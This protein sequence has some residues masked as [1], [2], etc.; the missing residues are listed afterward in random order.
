M[1]LKIF[2]L[3]VLL[4]ITAFMLHSFGW[5]GAPVFA[6]VAMVI[7]LSEAAGVLESVLLSARNMGVDVGLAEP[8]SAALKVLGLGYL[9]GICADVCRDMSESG[10]AKAV[11]AVGRVE[12]VAVVMPF[13][14]EIIKVGVELLG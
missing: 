6:S 3:A 10:I 12:I 9:Y 7:L 5:R 8:V 1:I 2:G 11:E 13:F 4:C 14:E